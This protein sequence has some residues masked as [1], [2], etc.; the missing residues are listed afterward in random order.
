MWPSFSLDTRIGGMH[1]V[2]LYLASYQADL[3]RREPPSGRGEAA[4]VAG[5]GELEA[6]RDALLGRL[7]EARGQAEQRDRRRAGARAR[8]DAMV[9]EPAA[10]KWDAVSAD[11]LGEPGCATYSVAPAAGPLGALM[12]WWRVKVSSGCP[13]AAPLEAARSEGVG[14]DGQ[15][16]RR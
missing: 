7:T 8:L 14:A 2:K 4:H 9:A 11:E 3:P 6:T 1:Q 12:R 16:R 13:L 5:V 15:N 10:R